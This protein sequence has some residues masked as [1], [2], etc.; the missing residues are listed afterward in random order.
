[1]GVAWPLSRVPCG[2]P[3]FTV[4]IADA[5]HIVWTR[6]NGKVGTDLPFPTCT[7]KTVKGSPGGTG[8]ATD[9]VRFQ[10]R[11]PPRALS[12]VP[13]TLSPGPGFL[14]PDGGFRPLPGLPSGLPFCSKSCSGRRTPQGSIPSRRV[15]VLLFTGLIRFRQRVYKKLM[16]TCNSIKVL[17]ARVR[18]TWSSFLCPKRRFEEAALYFETGFDPDEGL[19][20]QTG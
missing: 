11:P 10:P 2:S 12:G 5:W 1:M 20:Y 3:W 19:C 14:R 16:Y 6:G 13:G 9:R 17:Y 18:G 8:T 15:L 7:R 4:P